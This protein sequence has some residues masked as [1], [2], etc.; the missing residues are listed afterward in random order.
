M[1]DNLEDGTGVDDQSE[2]A[3]GWNSSKEDTH[4]EDDAASPPSNL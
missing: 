1:T 2:S 4:V 3:T